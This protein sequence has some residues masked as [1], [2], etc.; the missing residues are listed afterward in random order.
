MGKEMKKVKIKLTGT[1]RHIIHE[2]KGGTTVIPNIKY[3]CICILICNWTCF[4][5]VHGHS[6]AWN[7]FILLRKKIVFLLQIKTSDEWLPNTYE[8][9]DGWVDVVAFLERPSWSLESSIT[10]AKVLYGFKI[11]ENDLII[12]FVSIEI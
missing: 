2:T 8:R 6:C 7:F 1:Q 9:L 5:T 12:Y 4:L 10:F 3:I 11:E